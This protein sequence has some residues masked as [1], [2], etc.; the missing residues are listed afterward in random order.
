MLIVNS[1]RQ[2][3]GYLLFNLEPLHE[4]LMGVKVKIHIFLNY[5]ECE[6][7]WPASSTGILH[8]GT[9]SLTHCVRSSRL[10]SLSGQGGLQRTE[11]WSSTS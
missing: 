10:S 5:A 11:P 9:A 4:G 8:P 2:E 1:K 3:G 6:N 7:D